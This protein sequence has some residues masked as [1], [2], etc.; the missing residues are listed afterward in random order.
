MRVTKDKKETK[1]E[2]IKKVE[3]ELPEE[4]KVSDLDRL[5]RE[6]TEKEKLIDEGRNKLLRALADF[7]NYKKRMALDREEIIKFSNETLI[8]AILPI[9][10]GF[11]RAIEASENENTNEEVVKGIALV[12][13]Q[14]E[15]LLEKFGVKEIKA[16][17]KIFSGEYHEAIMQ[18]ESDS[19]PGCILEVAQRGYTLHGRVIRP[20]MVI[21][22]KKKE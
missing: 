1:K 3:K 18:K 20:S 21:I 22:S 8:T 5:N 17:G 2:E 6:I 4:A 9:I 19:P 15:D 11:E 14:L 12:K 13:K 16:L 7:D 10:D